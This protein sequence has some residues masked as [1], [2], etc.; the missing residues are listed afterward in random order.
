MIFVLLMHIGLPDTTW[1]NIQTLKCKMA[2]ILK[3]Q[4]SAIYPQ[5]VD[6]FCRNVA[7][8]CISVLWTQLANKIFSD[9]SKTV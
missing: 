3:N 1:Q 2:V 9:I 4:R 8:W 7:W 5:S 6:Q